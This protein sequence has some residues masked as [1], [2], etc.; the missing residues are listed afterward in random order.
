MKYA[1][2]PRISEALKLCPP[3]FAVS[4]QREELLLQL[5]KLFGEPFSEFSSELGRFYHHQVDRVL[6]EVAA[7][8]GSAPR[9]WKLYSSGFIIK[10][11]GKVIAFDINNGCVHLN[12][13]ASVFLK[14]SQISKLATLIDEYYV[15]HSHSDHISGELCDALVRRKKLL[16][17]PDECRHSWRVPGTIASEN[18][19]RTGMYAYLNWQGTA[20]GGLDCAMYHLALSNGKNVM[21]RGDIY[22][23]EGFSGCMDFLD[24]N[25]LDV[26]YVFASHYSTSGPE[27]IPFLDGK[28]HCRFIPI[29]EWEFSHR[30]PG[31]PGAATQCFEELYRVYKNC[32]QQNRAQILSW[33]ESI[34]LD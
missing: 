27:P 28:Y 34:A 12:G 2:L 9:F 11:A 10:D 30:K 1:D 15:T 26:D 17:M 20:A 21:V 22:H 6:E 33:G 29:H 8:G 24:Q 19:K 23:A 14:P 4:K 16:V 18:L 13:R 5:D 7:Y 31:K 25:K 32:Y 3:E